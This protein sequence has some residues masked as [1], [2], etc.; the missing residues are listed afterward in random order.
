M[1][2]IGPIKDCIRIHK[3]G[4]TIGVFPE[5]NRSYDGRLC[6]I[7]DAI[8]KMAKMMKTDVVI[9]NIVG[10]YG[11]DPRWCYKARRG[12]SYGYVKRVITAEEV[13]TLDVSELFEII[14]KELTVPQIPTAI[15]YKG[16]RLAEGLERI[17]YICPLCGK[18]QTIYTKGDYVYCT[19]C[20]LKV[21]YN[22]NLEFSSENSDF[23]FTYV[24]DWYDYQMS[25]LKEFDINTEGTI[26]ED[27]IILKLVEKSKK[28][29]LLK[30]TVVLT[31][32]EIIVSNEKDTFKFSLDLIFSMTVLGKNK[33]N[34]YYDNKIYQFKGSR[35]LN[36]LKYMHIYYHIK[37]IKEGIKDVYFGM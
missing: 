37:N 28:K 25:K 21:K 7:D 1:K 27:N 10:G 30:G 16:R 22:E 14:K 31:K 32:D 36:T 9:Y 15:K 12:K 34:F 13:K 11:I 17:L 19:C 35:T 23:K 26:F 3:E 4:G 33:L 8:A 18:V 24:E 2:E 29:I 6:Y 20:D 5:G